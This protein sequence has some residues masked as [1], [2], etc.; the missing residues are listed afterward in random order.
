M[1]KP[2]EG[3]RWKEEG[4]ESKSLPLQATAFQSKQRLQPGAPTAAEIHM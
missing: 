4:K 1:V 3:G 2:E